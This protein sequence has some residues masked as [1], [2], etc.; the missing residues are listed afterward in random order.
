M[1]Y[2]V[3]G[4]VV[5][6][7]LVMLLNAWSDLDDLRK[8]Y[9]NEVDGTTVLQAAMV[10]AR[11]SRDEWRKQADIWENKYHELMGRM[12][13]A[14]ELKDDS[15]EDDDT[16]VE[17]DDGL[18]EDAPGVQLELGKWYVDGYD[19]V[20]GPITETEPDEDG[21]EEDYP[22]CGY[23]PHHEDIDY[24]TRDGFFFDT[25]NECPNNI[26]REATEEE[27]ASCKQSS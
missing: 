4:F 23:N 19:H 5:V 20:I 11:K 25:K 9:Y 2:V 13:I 3:L 18:E 1:V 22:L 8:D 12:R 17:D 21:I 15:S 26:K 16:E 7:L 6:L 10:D 24:F 14:I 27:I